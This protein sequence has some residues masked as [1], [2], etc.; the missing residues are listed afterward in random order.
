MKGGGTMA[1]T[2]NCTTLPGY[3]RPYLFQHKTFQ[4]VP[5]FPDN[6]VCSMLNNK[7]AP[8]H[9]SPPKGADCSSMGQRSRAAA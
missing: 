1:K 5:I 7:G 3:M 6:V 9:P 8:H 4:Q 2:A